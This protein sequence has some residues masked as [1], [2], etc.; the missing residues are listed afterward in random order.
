MSFLAN[1]V[2][3]SDM[4]S[5]KVAIF[6]CS[7]LPLSPADNVGRIRSVGGFLFIDLVGFDMLSYVIKWAESITVICKRLMKRC[8]IPADLTWFLPHCSLLSSPLPAVISA[9]LNGTFPFFSISF[10]SSESPPVTVTAIHTDL[11]PRLEQLECLESIFHNAAIP[12][13][14]ARD[15]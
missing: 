9:I 4:A 14:R 15:H 1:S 12:K 10:Y 6:F 7:S 8:P 2:C 13:L 11:T 5:P 3:S